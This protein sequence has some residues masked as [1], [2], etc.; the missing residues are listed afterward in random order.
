MQIFVRDFTG[1]GGLPMNV[2]EGGDDAQVKQKLS[3]GQVVLG[4][5]LASRANVK[6]GDEITLNTAKGPR[7][8]RV[9]GT[10]TIYL[11]G[12]LAIYMEG[13]TARQLLDVEG[14]N[15]YVIHTAP[16]AGADVYERLKTLC[17]ENGLML[18]SFADLRRRVDSIIT[19]VV[20]SL[21]GILALGFLVGAFGIAN[22]LT[23]NVLENKPATWPCCGWSP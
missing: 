17:D 7:Q 23:M 6:V 18:Q 20:A 8:L 2:K 11:N 5:V 1:E 19:G 4:T 14:V 12:G 16:N 13:N 21:W 22:T 3:E 15:M 10:T 9:A